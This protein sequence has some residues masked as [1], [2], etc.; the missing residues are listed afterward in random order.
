MKLE[1]HGLVT[2]KLVW[3]D[4]IPDGH[5]WVSH[6]EMIKEINQIGSCALVGDASGAIACVAI[7]VR[8]PRSNGE[9]SNQLV[10]ARSKLLDNGIT[11]PR[12]E[13]AAFLKYPHWRSGEKIT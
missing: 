4:A 7:Y 11:Q 5:V 2:R 6:M 12:A 9:Y 1:L 8:F 10:F 13:L 3:D